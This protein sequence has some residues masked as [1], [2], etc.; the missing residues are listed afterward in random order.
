VT[1]EKV[2]Q[3]DGPNFVLPLID[4]AGKEREMTIAVGIFITT[5]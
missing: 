4:I 1:H 3:H 5:K 2:I